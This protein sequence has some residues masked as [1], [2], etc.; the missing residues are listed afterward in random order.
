VLSKSISAFGL[1]VEQLIAESTGK[2]GKGLLPVEGEKLGTPANY[3]NDRI[4]VHIYA[5][6]DEYKSDERKLSA[7]E[8]EGHPVVRISI[9]DKL[10]LGAEYLRWE[11]ATATAGVVIG[12]DAFN[13]PNVAESK[14][15]TKEL[16]EEWKQKGSFSEGEPVVEK[17]GISIY[18][19]QSADWLFEGHRKNVKDFL[20]T[21]VKLSKSP[22]YFS[23][24]AY[25][26]QTPVRH[27]HLQVIRYSVK[28]K[29]KIATTL[30][31]G[32]RYLHSTGQL[33]K[34]GANTGVFVI[35]TA[36]ANEEIQIPGSAYGFAT[37]QRSQA[38]GDLRSLNNK[39]RR[40][41]RIHLGNDIEGGLKKLSEMLK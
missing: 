27:K 9:Q 15:N 18:C 37:L 22:D 14:S 1:W 4:F 10:A 28:D 3:S 34:G 24:L 35:L 23:I 25:F 33:H 21:Y 13:Q 38:L 36:D 8:K 12:I 31:Y 16:L 29:F 40:V 2:D 39:E 19:N 11:I 30:G 5:E 41:V 26:L 17:D 7:L 6:D 32:P 20:S